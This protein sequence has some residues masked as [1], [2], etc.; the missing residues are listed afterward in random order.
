MSIDVKMPH[1]WKA[2][3]TDH[4]LFYA[5]NSSYLKRMPGSRLLISS[6]PGKALRMLVDIASLAKRF[7]MCSQSR[8]WYSTISLPIVSLVKPAFMT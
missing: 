1:C 5:S 4:Y 3:V 8:A 7:N 2:H 6:L